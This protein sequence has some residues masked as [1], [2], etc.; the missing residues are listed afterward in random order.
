VVSTSL[1]SPPILARH[2]RVCVWETGRLRVD[3]TLPAP[4]AASLADL[5]PN[6]VGDSLREREV[7]VAAI[8]AE[9]VRRHFPPG[10]LFLMEEGNKRV[11][12]W[13]E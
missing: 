3:L 9:T 11:R 13:L 2:L 7:D 12:V 6:D 1:F 5:V 4:L 10:E 8:A